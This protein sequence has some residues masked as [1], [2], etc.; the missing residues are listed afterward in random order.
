MR[1]K[2]IIILCFFY[3]IFYS[4]NWS[5]L[6]TNLRGAPHSLFYDS[7]TNSMLVGG[8]FYRV[9]NND[10][11]VGIGFYKNNQW[12][13]MGDG[14]DWN[15]QSPFCFSCLPNPVNSIIRFNDTIY[16]TGAFSWT[17]IGTTTTQLNGIAKWDGIKWCPIGNGLQI[18]LGGNGVGYKFKIYNNEL[19]LAGGFDSIAGVSAHG[20]AKFN[21]TNWTAVNN[22][23][24][25]NPSTSNLAYDVEFFNSEIYVGGIMDNGSTLKDIVKWNGTSWINPGIGMY[26]LGFITG[27]TR[28]KN[29]LYV[30][31]SYSYFDHPS[32][33]GN[34]LVKFNGTSWMGLGTG[35]LFNPTSQSSIYGYKT[36][37]NNL[38]LGGKFDKCNE[39]KISY[40]TVFDG[41][42]FC[43]L[44]TT[45]IFS[46]GVECLEFF[47]DTLYVGGY[48]KQGSNGF[49][50]GVARCKNYNFNDKC[51]ASIVGI[52]E[53]NEK[54]KS[55]F[56]FPNPAS[57]TLFISSETNEFENSETEIT[58]CLG[59]IVLKL[60][61]K[62]EI[63]VSQLS[64]GC[65]VLKITTAEKKQF[66]SKFLKE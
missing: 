48:L 10:T 42:K 20:L 35:I 28:Y 60:P 38:Y 52:A 29:D 49:S 47:K 18:N 40:V 61:Y 21:G 56:L 41:S 51:S 13:R 2:Y 26:G 4:Q 57:N 55:V 3:G 53:I 8:Q 64:S 32:N 43:S 17:G 23:P 6:D 31:G 15:K 45:T 30:I 11:I 34:S 25:I 37:N 50:I 59:Q 66:Y 27:I 33:P 16:I 58:N 46:Q 5:T 14:V 1:V 65:Y 62:N 36:Y 7:I 54:P 19:Y 63:D 44:D 39:S 12:Y 9:F 22:L 24:R